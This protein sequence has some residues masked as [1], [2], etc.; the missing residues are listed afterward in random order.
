MPTPPEREPTVQSPGATLKE[1][2][3]PW[4]QRAPQQEIPPWAKK[5]D[6]EVSNLIYLHYLSNLK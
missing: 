3:R 5:E 6:V 1:A 2:P 4:Q